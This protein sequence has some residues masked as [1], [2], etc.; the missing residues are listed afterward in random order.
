MSLENGTTRT[1]ILSSTVRSLVRLKWI[2]I[3]TVP[4][5][6]R[7]AFDC[8]GTLTIAFPRNGRSISV[9]YEHTPIHQTVAQLKEIFKPAPRPQPPKKTAESKTPKSSR[10]KTSKESKAPKTPKTP[11]TPRTPKTGKDGESKE[12]KKSA[13]TG[14]EG[15]KPRKRKKKN[16]G[17]PQSVGNE[18]SSLFV[19]ADNPAYGT[20]PAT[21]SNAGSVAAGQS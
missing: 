17:E 10:P 3:L 11:K 2:Q 1:L 5:L 21:A 8:R 19:D 6:D 16:D 20:P 18:S 4:S 13:S 14:G 7:P 9:K 15:S 12:K